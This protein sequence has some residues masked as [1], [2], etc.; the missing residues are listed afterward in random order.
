[1]DK[2]FDLVDLL[3][4]SAEDREPFEAHQAEQMQNHFAEQVIAAKHRKDE[5]LY[6][7]KPG[8][9]LMLLRLGRVDEAAEIMDTWAGTVDN[10]AAKYPNEAAS[11]ACG[12]TGF[13]YVMALICQRQG[14]NP[15]QHVDAIA[16]LSR[17]AIQLCDSDEWLYGRAGY[18]FACLSLRQELQTPAFDQITREVAEKMIH[19]GVQYAQVHAP[20]LHAVA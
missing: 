11:L 7:G 20:T 6:T 10:M 12:A 13:H 9:A 4:H 5:S 19:S 1:M 14:N 15:A 8:V 16:K 18:L 17:N 3:R 2:C